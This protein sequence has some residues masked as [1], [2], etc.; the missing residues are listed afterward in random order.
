MNRFLSRVFSYN[1]YLYIYFQIS[2]KCLFLV[3]LY[4]YNIAMQNIAI[5][6]CIDVLLN[7]VCEKKWSMQIKKQERIDPAHPSVQLILFLRA[8]PSSFFR[9]LPLVCTVLWGLAGWN[10]NFPRHW[11]LCLTCVCCLFQPCFSAS[12]TRCLYILINT[13]FLRPMPI[14][15]DLKIWYIGRYFIFCQTHRT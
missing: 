3:S 4:W 11:L 12:F 6:S 5:P 15:D 10:W 7:V 14:L 13:E 1:Y 9:C 2:I 8:W